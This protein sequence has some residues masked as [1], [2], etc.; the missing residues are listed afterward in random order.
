ME[1]VVRVGVAHL[2]YFQSYHEIDRRN[3]AI[4]ELFHLLY[5]DASF[6]LHKHGHS[7]HSPIPFDLLFTL[8]EGSNTCHLPRARWHQYVYR[9][10][11][12]C[13]FTFHEGELQAL[14]NPSVN[15][16]DLFL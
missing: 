13:E 2:W 9:C 6:L 3:E 8:R 16:I 10:S 15:Y 5:V 1:G 14:F 12:R 11:Q 7:L 4:G